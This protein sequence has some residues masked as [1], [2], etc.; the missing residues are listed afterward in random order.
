M[1]IYPRSLKNILLKIGLVIISLMLAV[2]LAE[3]CLKLLTPSVTF[4]AA[5]ELPWM[6]DWKK[7]NGIHGVF[8]IDPGFGFRP[9]LGNAIYNQYG[10]LENYYKLEKPLHKIRL[11]FIGDSVTSRGKIIQALRNIYG[12]EN[13][14]YWN[15]GVESFN[16]VQEV[17]FY[18]KYNSKIKPDQVI[19]SFHPNDFET[20]PIAFYDQDMRLIVYAPKRPLQEISP[21]LFQHSLLYR[22]F[23]RLTQGRDDQNKIAQEVQK[24]LLD[25]KTSLERDKIPFTVLMLPLMKPYSRWNQEDRDRRATT[26]RILQGEHIRYFDLSTVLE[27]AWHQGL[28]LQQTPGDEAHPNDRA[29]AILAA[30]LAERHLLQN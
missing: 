17:A 4:N 9:V 10:T 7:P 12:E 6:H 28:T 11:L 25:L 5:H 13:F 22:F 18:K 26:L 15:A 21:W 24:N 1:R 2:A 27:G 19:L 30:Y 8:M 23:L 20:T 3:G 29:G 14:E 16:T